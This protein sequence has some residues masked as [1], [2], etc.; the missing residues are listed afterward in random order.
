[1]WRREGDDNRDRVEKWGCKDEEERCMAFSNNIS[2]NLAMLLSTSC[3]V[4]KPCNALSRLFT[5]DK[6][7]IKTSTRTSLSW[8]EIKM[9]TH[10]EVIASN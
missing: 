2:C 8:T 10:I 6:Q 4:A 3:L 7:L 9:V 5:D 1:M